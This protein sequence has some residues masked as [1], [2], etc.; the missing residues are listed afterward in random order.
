MSEP[1]PDTPDLDQLFRRDAGRLVA[2]LGRVFGAG[3]LD[4]AEDVVQD[5][6]AAALESWSWRGVPERPDAWLATVARNR[7]IDRLRREMR[8]P[9]VAPGEQLAAPAAAEDVLLPPPLADDTLRLMF[10]CGH[11]ALGEA[12]QLALMLKTVCG[13]SVEEI[14]AAF[15][16]KP[17]AVAQRLVRAKAR[18]RELK[19]PFAVP[20]PEEMA[21]RLR[22]VLRGVYL[23][24]DAGYRARNGEALVRDALCREAV[25][26]IEL[27]TAEP[28]TARPETHALAALIMLHHARLPARLAA[29]GSLLTLEQQDR[30]LWDALLIERGFRHLQAA[31]H[32]ELLT[33]YHL[34]A[35]IA[36]AHAAAA[37]FGE[38]DWSAIVGWYDALLEIAPGPVVAMNRAVAVALRDGPAA[39]LALL[40][41]LARDRRLAAYGPFHATLGELERRHGDHIAAAAA[42]RLAL[43]LRP[44]AAERRLLEARLAACG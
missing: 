17:P 23:L 9:A 36:A 19:L 13:F 11:P 41:P 35:G 2:W 4:L 26:L 29:D 16:G 14:A 12:T 1:A 22:P 44:N 34:E 40:R 15:L 6:L 30:S 7:A 43:A 28:R 21:A 37:S 42:F 20:E 32:G 25:R 10:V 5:A 27:L 8:L 24:F 3:R 18:I 38:T 31:R 39:G 33:A